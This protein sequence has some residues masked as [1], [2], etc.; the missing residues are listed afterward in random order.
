MVW[1]PGV[2]HLT[3]PL[4]GRMGLHCPVAAPCFLTQ[5]MEIVSD[6]KEGT[7]QAL[8]WLG[9]LG[10][11]KQPMNAHHPPPLCPFVPKMYITAYPPPVLES[12][13]FTTKVKHFQAQPE[14]S[15]DV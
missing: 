5:D 8:G 13:C 11:H 7:N 14:T 9:V 4:I 10:G 15:I 3:E 1:V 6:T 2:P 12:C